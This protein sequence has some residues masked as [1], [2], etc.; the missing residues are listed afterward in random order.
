[1]VELLVA[2]VLTSILGGVVLTVVLGVHSSAATTQSQQ[3]LNEEARLALNRIAREL[4][5]ANA[6]IAVTNPDG[7][8]Y[9]ATAITTATFTADFNGD[10]CINVYPLNDNGCSEYNPN[11]PE[12]LTYCWD[13]TSTVRE[14]F[15]IPGAFT[16]STCQSA[17][18]QAILAGEV[19]SFKLSYRSNDYLADGNND[20][21]TTW[22]ELDA[23]GAP[24]G[25]DNATLDT[26]L[27]E[28]DTVVIDIT[29]SDDGNHAQTYTTEVD[30]RNLT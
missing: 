22:S 8:S 26:E 5:Q 15:L 19:T 6:L 14:L 21:L 13:P 28:I 17:S 20:G 1:M 2:M 30:L 16:G 25:N 7:S 11:D 23:Y 18:A 10:G 3:N 29:A 4:R 27:S 9:D 24:Y 12:E